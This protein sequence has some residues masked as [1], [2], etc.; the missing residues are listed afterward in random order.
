MIPR[1]G[2]DRGLRRYWEVILS[3]D[4]ITDDCFYMDGF[5]NAAEAV[6]LWLQGEELTH[7]RTCKEK[8]IVQSPGLRSEVAVS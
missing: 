4:S 3:H 2:V 5:E 7:I 6:L 1:S 8:C